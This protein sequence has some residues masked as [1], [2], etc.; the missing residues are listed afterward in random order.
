M[1]YM[2]KYILISCLLLY[3]CNHEVKTKVDRQIVVED[4]Q[5]ER[6]DNHVEYRSYTDTIYD[7]DHMLLCDSNILKG[8]ENNLQLIDTITDSKILNQVTQVSDEGFAFYCNDDTLYNCDSLLL[9]QVKHYKLKN[10]NL[11]FYLHGFLVGQAVHPESVS[12]YVLS[13]VKKDS[14]LFSEV[15]EDIMGEIIMNLF[16]AEVG[17]DNVKIWG[18]MYPYFSHTGYG[19]FIMNIKNGYSSSMFECEESDH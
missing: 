17:N 14:I 10:S 7:C 13:V 19:R 8:Y 3:A 15:H 4:L 6:P 2:N 9:K 12:L 16:G 18:E 1:H 11:D 5:I